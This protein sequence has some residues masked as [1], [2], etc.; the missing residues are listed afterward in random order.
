MFNKSIQ[1]FSD[2]GLVQ[3]VFDRSIYKVNEGDVA[4][5]VSLTVA[6]IDGDGMPTPI[7]DTG[8]ISKLYMLCFNSS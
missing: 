7:E 3:A 6:F 5:T 4:T 8:T 1:F 2:A